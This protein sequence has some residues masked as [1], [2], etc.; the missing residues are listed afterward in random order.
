MKT[1]YWRLLSY[2]ELRIL[3]AFDDI[4]A[5]MLSNKKLNPIETKLFIRG[6]KLN[7]SFVFITQFYFPLPKHVGLSSTHCFVLW[8][9]EANESLNKSR[10]IISQI[11]TFK[12][13]IMN[14]YKKINC[15][16]MFFFSDWYYSCIW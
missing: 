14:L 11:L 13:F 2:K 5:D 3:T 16:I 1:K 6:K 4:I 9:F 8:K 15:E 7:I 10:L 12:T